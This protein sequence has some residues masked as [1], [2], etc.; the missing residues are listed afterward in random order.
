MTTINNMIRQEINEYRSLNKTGRHYF[1]R[2][3]AIII[4]GSI[5][6]IALIWLALNGYLIEYHGH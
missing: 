2:N 1:W 5:A 6:V 3:L 4:G